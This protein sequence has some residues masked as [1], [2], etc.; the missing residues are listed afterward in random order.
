MKKIKIGKIPCIVFAVSMVLSCFFVYQTEMQKIKIERERTQYITG[1]QASKLQYVI[2]SL[3][4]KTQ[5]LEMLVVEENGKIEKFEY[6]CEKLLDNE[7]IRSL[8]LAPD[9]VVTYV[10]PLKGNED[11]FGDL[12]SDPDR[13]IEAEYARDSGKMTLA[14]PYELTQGGM[15][16]VARRPIYLQDENNQPVFWGFSII[17]LDIPEAFSSVELD[18]FV[19]E[20][21]EYKLHRINPNTNKTQIIDESSTKKLLKPI[22]SSFE[23]PNGMWTFSVAP[24]GGWISVPELA[25]KLGISLVISILFFL[26]TLAAVELEHQ[27][28]VMRNLSFRD[29]LT[30]LN[31][32]RML[33][34]TFH[35]LSVQHTA[36]SLFYL[37][38]DGFKKINDT[39]GH[40]C[41]DLFLIESAQRL[42]QA[43]QKEAMIFR[44]GGDEFAM[45]IEKKLPVE[46]CGEILD[47]IAAV[48]TKSFEIEKYRITASASVGCA[49]YPDDTKSI[50]ELIHIADSSMYEMKKER[51][52]HIKLAADIS[53]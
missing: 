35:R 42:S 40:A 6:I 33:M 28:K 5:T 41:G 43:F 47:R 10:Y 31:N 9:G 46:A 38:F 7:A 4:L 20:G 32:Q 12:F 24:T 11:A 52:S 48:F 3:L 51:K 27:R 29:S 45:I 16:M 26:L 49:R 39:Y 36:F 21:F 2:D 25:F 17:I 19:E 14:G 13:K 53:K 22:D 15:G 34:E 50:E 23:V 1:Y 30:G 8:Q 44:I 18:K 37:D